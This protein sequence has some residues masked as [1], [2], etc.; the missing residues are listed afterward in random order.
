MADFSSNLCGTGFTQC[1]DQPTGG[2]DLMPIQEVIYHR[3]QYYNHGDYQ[4]LV[5]SFVVDVDETEHGGVRWFELR[6]E[7]SGWNLFQEGTYSIDAAD[8]WMASIAMD[9]S[10]NIAVAYSTVSEA[11]PE[12]FNSLRYTG[13]LAED[14]PRCH[15]AAR[16]DAER[17]LR[18]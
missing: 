8:R 6:D 17:R 15:D 7:G 18:G 13:R 3:L 9:Q 10:G 1:F 14:P 2:A 12:I 5:G 11:D 4:T 16:G